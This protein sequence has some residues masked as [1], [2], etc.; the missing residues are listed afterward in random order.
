MQKRFQQYKKMEANKLQPRLKN[1]TSL[2]ALII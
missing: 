2:N 1:G